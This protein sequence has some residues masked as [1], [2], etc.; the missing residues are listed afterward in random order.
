MV[1]PVS[2]RSGWSAAAIHG[3]APQPVLDSHHLV[4]PSGMDFATSAATSSLFSSDNAGRGNFWPTYSWA[5]NPWIPDHREQPLRERKFDRLRPCVVADLHI[6]RIGG[7][8][9]SFVLST[10][11]AVEHQQSKL[12]RWGLAILLSAP[13]ISIGGWLQVWRWLHLRNPPQLKSIN[14]WEP[15]TPGRVQSIMPKVG[16]DQPSVIPL[17][18]ASSGIH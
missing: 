13:T 9:Y 6:V 8:V 16:C 17:E 10:V 4:K 5:D 14:A 2:P 1:G 11:G 3:E 18:Q 7:K 15:T 12:R